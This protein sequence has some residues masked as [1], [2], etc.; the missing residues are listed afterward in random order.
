MDT[1]P[2][3]S[4]ARPPTFASVAEMEEFFQWSTVTT[5]DPVTMEYYKD[6]GS[7]AFWMPFT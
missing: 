7:E 2:K 3:Y 1:C 6:I 4:R 5:K